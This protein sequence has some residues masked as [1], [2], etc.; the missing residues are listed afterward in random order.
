MLIVNAP[1]PGIYRVELP[2]AEGVAKG[3][4]SGVPLVQKYGVPV[5][6]VVVK[7]KPPLYTRPFALTEV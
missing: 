4:S 7:Y 5:Q 2:G 1:V 6:S 3:I